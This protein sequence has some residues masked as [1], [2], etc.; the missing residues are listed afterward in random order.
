MA[1]RMDRYK[2]Q[3][4]VRLGRSEKNQSLYEQIASLDSYTNIE[5]VA[6]IEKTNEID[7]SKVKEMLKNRENFKKQKEIERISKKDNSSLEE[8]DDVE[9]IIKEEKRNYDINDILKQL[10]QNDNIESKEH[11][12]LNEKQYE[13]LKKLKNKSKKSIYEKINAEETEQNEDFD[14]TD[15]VGLLDDLKSST[16]VGD[17]SSIK[18]IIEEEKNGLKIEQDPQIDRSFY[19]TNFGLTK[20]DFEEIQLQQDGP[21]K[22]NTTIIIIIIVVLLIVIGICGFLIFK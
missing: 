1:S 19:T 17:A 13:D 18:K 12:R 11:R 14:L 2:N 6:T 3:E 8:K 15:D 22:K 5:G 16:M 7:I 9:N 4:P 20:K 10:K 21:K